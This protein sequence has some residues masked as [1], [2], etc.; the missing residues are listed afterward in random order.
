MALLFR[1][2]GAPLAALAAASNPARVT[3]A[4]GPAAAPVGRALFSSTTGLQEKP[5]KYSEQQ[6]A[7]GRPV[8]PH[9]TIYA[10]PVVAISSI[11]VR[12]TGVLLTI[13]AS[14]VGL[15]SF[16]HPDIAGLMCDVGNSSAGPLAKFVV[17]FPLL[18][19]W[20]GGLRHTIWDKMSD[21]VNNKAV[22]QSSYAIFGLGIAGSLGAA[23][24]TGS[25]PAV[26]KEKGSA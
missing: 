15:L 10:F 19:H 13:G 3:L 22:E 17:A 6:L 5:L 1:H 4:R 18:Y 16:V 21:T 2:R 7:M 9:V 20:L 26:E 24:Y 25:A 8:S 14:G 23:A 12:V 11:T